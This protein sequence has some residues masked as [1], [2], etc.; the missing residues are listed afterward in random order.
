MVCVRSWALDLM[1]GLA[2]VLL[3]TLGARYASGS[4]E[5]HR[6]SPRPSV[7]RPSPWDAQRCPEPVPLGGELSEL[8][9]AIGDLEAE[10]RRV[11]ALPWPWPEDPEPHMRPEAVQDALERAREQHPEQFEGWTSWVDCSE[12]PC[13]V[14]S[15]GGPELGLGPAPRFPFGYGTFSTMDSTRHREARY[16]LEESGAWPE[17]L[18]RRLE[19]RRVVL[20]ALDTP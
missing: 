1:V 15:E 2:G 4:Q 3:G 20:M 6:D 8:Q 18:Q 12:Y 5:V 16:P 17:A 7:A 9:E 19:A 10:G 11:G 14:I 13:M